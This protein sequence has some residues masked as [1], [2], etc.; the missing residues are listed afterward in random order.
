MRRVVCAVLWRAEQRDTHT[1]ACFSRVCSN[2]S[3]RHS[4]ASGSPHRWAT[5]RAVLGLCSERAGAIPTTSGRLRINPAQVSPKLAGCDHGPIDALLACKRP[6]RAR[7]CLKG[8]GTPNFPLGCKTC[9]LGDKTKRPPQF[10]QHHR[11]RPDNGTPRYTYLDSPLR[12]DGTLAP[13]ACCTSFL[14][15]LRARGRRG[16]PPSQ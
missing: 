2:M 11:E 3:P 7:A 5:A 6:R 12:G 16:E 15:P 1:C 8:G 10:R 14:P 13:Q 9:G 4:C